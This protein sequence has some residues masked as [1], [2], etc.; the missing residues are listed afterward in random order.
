MQ[1]ANKALNAL[2]LEILDSLAAQGA[3]SEFELV[4]KVAGGDS[5]VLPVLFACFELREQGFVSVD[6]GEQNIF[7]LTAEGQSFL[8][9]SRAEA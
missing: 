6:E 2:E 3:Q 1:H 8:L 7:R 4:P 5:S 9:A